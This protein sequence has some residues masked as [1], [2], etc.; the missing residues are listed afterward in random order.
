MEARAYI[1]NVKISPKKLR[2]LLPELK[3]RQPSEALH[4]LFYTPKKSARIFYKAIKSAL[5]NAKSTLGVGEDALIF[6]TLTVEEGQK[7]KRFK[8]GGRGRAKP[9]TRRHAHIKVVLKAKE[10]VKAKQAEEKVR[11]EKKTK[12]I[13]A[14]AKPKRKTKK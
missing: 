2:F 7:L 1:K 6:K 9:F 8:A 3:K 10:T 12:L 11:E 5:D 4:Y 13:E 14:S